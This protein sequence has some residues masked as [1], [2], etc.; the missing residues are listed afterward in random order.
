M[1]RQR[2]LKFLFKHHIRERQLQYRKM[3]GWIDS[4]GTRYSSE[5]AAIITVMQRFTYHRS[6]HV[7]VDFQCCVMSSGQNKLG[8]LDRH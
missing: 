8:M 5:I 1:R 6:V 7:K 4:G 3:D 2:Q